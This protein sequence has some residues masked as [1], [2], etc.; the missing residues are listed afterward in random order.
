MHVFER[1][2]LSHNDC[3]A[4]FGP[5]T[6]HCGQS[7]SHSSPIGGG[8][9]RPQAQFDTSSLLTQAFSFGIKTSVL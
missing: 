8:P 3:Y 4:D 5:G 6:E 2:F 1:L 9:Q 7:E